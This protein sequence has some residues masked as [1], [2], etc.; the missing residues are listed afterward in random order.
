M[1]NQYNLPIVTDTSYIPYHTIL[2][3][4]KQGDNYYVISS[5]GSENT[6]GKVVDKKTMQEWLF[7]NHTYNLNKDFLKSDLKL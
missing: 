4:Q 7:N 2:N 3:I 6:A 1:N 5:V